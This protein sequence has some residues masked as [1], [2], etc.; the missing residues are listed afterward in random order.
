MSEKFVKMV[1]DKNIPNTIEIRVEGETHTLG[2]SLADEI[3]RDSRCKFST[4]KV[5]HPMEEHMFLKVC[6]DG[7][8]AVKDLI[9]ENLKKLENSTQDLINQLI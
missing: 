2:S 9:I 1:Y 7:T 3:A 4:Y 5:N 8:C 6:S